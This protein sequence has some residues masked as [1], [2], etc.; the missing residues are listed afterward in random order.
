MNVYRKIVLRFF[1]EHQ[2]VL[3]AIGRSVMSTLTESD[4]QKS[5]RGSLVGPLI[6]KLPAFVQGRILKSAS[7]TLEK[8]KWW[9]PVGNKK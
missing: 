3:S 4:E 1:Q 5:N 2:Q 8:G 9:N 6:S 7:E